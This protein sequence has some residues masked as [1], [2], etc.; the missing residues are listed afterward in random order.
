MCQYAGGKIR[1]GKK[2]HD[3]IREQEFKITGENAMCYFEPFLGMGGVMKH[4]A[5]TGNR[6]SI[7]G[8]D[9]EEDIISFW[10]GL[11]NGW[12]PVVIN[13]DQFIEMKKNG[14]KSDPMYAFTSCGCSFR[15]IK[16]VQFCEDGMNRAIKRLQKTDFKN[17]I[18]DVVFLDHAC[19]TSHNPSGLLIYCDPPYENSS[20]K[21]GASNLLKFD[22]DLF[23]ETMRSW[24]KDNIVIISER[25]APF[26]FECIAE[27]PRTNGI[28]KK[29]VVEKL[30]MFID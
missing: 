28:T 4:V 15:G 3:I 13:K 11:Q 12:K 10:K 6:P 19:Y 5:C 27:F 17:I 2:I 16:W 18:K 24:S 7:V 20:F 9:S 25:Y 22:S 8:C 26:D 1:I 21:W 30:F 23:W 14:E 29:T